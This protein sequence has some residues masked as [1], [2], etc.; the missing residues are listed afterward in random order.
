MVFTY[1]QSILLLVVFLALF[2]SIL[3]LF[4]IAQDGFFDYL[5]LRLIKK[6]CH[7]VIEKAKFYW[8]TGF[9]TCFRFRERFLDF[10]FRQKCQTG[11]TLAET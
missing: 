11:K 2:V 9:G 1:R 6:L 4:D 8:S 7:M 3:K 5:V 10:G